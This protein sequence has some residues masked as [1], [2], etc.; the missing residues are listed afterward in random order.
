[1]SDYG[2]LFLFVFAVLTLLYFLAQSEAYLLRVFAII[3]KIQ[4]AWRNLKPKFLN[5]SKCTKK[6]LN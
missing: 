2:Q 3:Q 1:M 6:D 5:D 4:V